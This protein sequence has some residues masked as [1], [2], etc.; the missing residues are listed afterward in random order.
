MKNKIRFM[1]VAASTT[2]IISQLLPYNTTAK[3]NLLYETFL[4]EEIICFT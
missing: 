2:T 3:R 1:K 4:I